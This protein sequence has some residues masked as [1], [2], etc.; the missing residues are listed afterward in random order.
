MA[1]HLPQGDAWPRDPGT[2]L[3]GLAQLF[4]G[5]LAR[6]DQRA[7]DLLREADPRQTV[8]LLADWEA[9][10]GLPD[11]CSAGVTLLDARRA[12][13]VARLTERRDPTPANIIA[14]AAAYGVE[15]AITE[16]RPHTCEGDCEE[17]IA[18]DAW[19][20]AWTIW[21]PDR[22]VTDRSCEDDCET[23]LRAWASLPH[24]C[25]VRRM[26]PA[27][28][29]PLFA[30][31]Q[32]EWDFAG[33]LPAGATLT[34][35]SSAV[36]TDARGQLAERAA[37]VARIDYDPALLYNL[38]PN[39]W[40]DGGVIGG[41]L[42]DT[43]LA[44]GS[45]G[46][47]GTLL[48]R[49]VLPDG[50][51]YVDVR[52]AGTT[53]STSAAYIY[54]CRIAGSADIPITVG[55]DVSF[56]IGVQV[57]AVTSTS[58]LL[59]RAY[60]GGASTF[61]NAGFGTVEVPAGAPLARYRCTDSMDN[62][63]STCATGG[64]TINGYASGE[65][66]SVDLRIC[67]PV[68]N[69]GTAIYLTDTVPLAI[70]AARV[71]GVPQYGLRALLVEEDATNGV[72][73]PRLEG[74][75]IGVPGTAPTGLTLSAGTTGLSREIVA[76][77]VEDGVP[78]MDVRFYG[79]ATATSAVY[80]TWQAPASAPAVAPGQSGYA[81]S[82]WRLVGGSLA[83]VVGTWNQVQFYDA[84]NVTLNSVQATATP[85]DAPILAQHVGLAW[86]ATDPATAKATLQSRFQVT[87]GAAVDFTIR[88]ALGQVV[89]G[90]RAGTPPLPAVG[91]PAAATR[92]ADVLRLAVPDGV[93]AI[94]ALGGTVD[95]AG[96]A[97]LGAG[98][99]SGG[100]LPFAWP[101]SAI[102]AGERHLQHITLRRIA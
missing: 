61:V 8:E 101:A 32:G 45:G 5:E 13:I 100:S 53:T 86:T 39:P 76:F 90:G 2:P 37:D 77:P 36:V 20:H 74:G 4:G 79:T 14:L 46:P 97:H 25:A 56:E 44:P 87:S 58:P 98:V 24:E 54:C 92:A 85:T 10:L 33:G 41:A 26:A 31:Y 83:G 65:A 91:T 30:S 12:A 82:H 62:V 75:V 73:N 18:D 40:G 28:T 59:V 52:I 19:A 67:L 57:L 80:L 102:A 47:T 51:P 50:S 81:A 38:L 22:L 55:D 93:Y 34:R 71:D 1:Q 21:S 94:G 48:A 3:H 9:E 15:A 66:V 49:G 7:A 60:V 72:Q 29:V 63:S 6:V 78:C 89:P 23:P 17:P 88:L 99:A 69:R 95:P 43:W 42:P 70:L 27:H 64:I 84:A 35:A 96:T 11:A 68:L 16:H